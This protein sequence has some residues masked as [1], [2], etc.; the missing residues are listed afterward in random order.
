[1]ERSRAAK[2]QWEVQAAMYAFMAGVGPATVTLKPSVER[3]IL[4]V[5]LR[6]VVSEEWKVER[7][8]GVEAAGTCSA[9]REGEA[10]K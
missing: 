1:M 6:E 7:R 5:R 8:E 2:L 3:R 4:P 9:G 10:A